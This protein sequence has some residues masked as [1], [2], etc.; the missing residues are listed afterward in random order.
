VPPDPVPTLS[1]VR[2]PVVGIRAASSIYLDDR[3]WNRLCAAVPDAWLRQH[4]ESGHLL[5]LEDPGVTASSVIEGLRALDVL[6]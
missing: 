4:S 1:R 3:R 5:P 2:L 6:S